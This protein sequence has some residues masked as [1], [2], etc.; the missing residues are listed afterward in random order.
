MT[1]SERDM[2][3]T[4]KHIR[5]DAEEMAGE[6]LTDVSRRTVISR[7]YYAAYH[8]CSR[9][10]GLLPHRSEHRARGGAHAQLIGR[11]KDP[12]PHCGLALMHRSEALG[13]LLERQFKRRVE[14][15]Y[16]LQIATDQNTM[17]QQLA[18]VRHLFDNCADPGS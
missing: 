16:E 18:D 13:K 14:A 12:N 17:D 11:L 1:R 15:D 10:E 8:R 9:W 6:A 2:Q 3:T 7:A 4:A 5:R